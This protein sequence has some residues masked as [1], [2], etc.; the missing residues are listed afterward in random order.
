MYQ[1]EEILV[2]VLSSSIE[3]ELIQAWALHQHPDC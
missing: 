2:P 1:T 3:N